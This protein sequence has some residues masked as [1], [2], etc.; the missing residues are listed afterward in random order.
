M[1]QVLYYWRYPEHGTGTVSYTTI[2]HGFAI[3]ENLEDYAFDYDK[4]TTTYSDDSSEEARQA[5]AELM[6]ACGVATE[7]DYCAYGSGTNIS[8]QMLISYFGIDKSCSQLYRAFFTTDKWEEIIRKELDEGRPVL[9]SGSSLEGGHQFVCDGYDE[10]GLYHIN[11]GWGGS[12]DGYYDLATLNPYDLAGTGFTADQDIIL[13][14]KPAEQGGEAADTASLGY[15]ALVNM[16]TGETA[17]GDSISYNIIMLRVTGNN[18]KGYIGTVLYDA[19]G[20][21]VDAVNEEEFELPIFYFYDYYP[22]NY[23]LPLDLA[24]GTYTLRPIYGTTQ[25]EWQPMDAVKGSHMAETI[26]VTV[27]NGVATVSEGDVKQPG[28]AIDGEVKPRESSIYAGSTVEVEI[29]IKNN[30]DY[31]NGYINV[32]S[33]KNDEPDFTDNMIIDAGETYVLL[34]ALPTDSVDT[35]NEFIVYF[36]DCNAR[37]DT[38]GTFTITSQIKAEGEPKISIEGITLDKSTYSTKDK[39][40]AYVTMSNEGGFYDGHPVAFVTTNERTWMYYGDGIQINKGEQ[41]IGTVQIDTNFL[42]ENC[43]V[44]ELSGLIIPGYYD[45]T[46]EEYLSSW[47]VVGFAVTEDGEPLELDLKLEGGAT[48]EGGKAYAG[49][50]ATVNFTLVNNG[51]DFYG[52]IGIPNYA[53]GTYMDVQET[54]IYAGESKDMQ[55]NITLQDEPGEQLYEVYYMDSFQN[56][57]L[58]GTFTITAERATGISAAEVGTE[59]KDAPVY[60]VSGQRVGTAAGLKSL[61]KG[62]YVTG[63]KKIVVK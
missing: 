29:P 47:Y 62:I 59:G 45:P 53:T 52:S 39:L 54:L 6:Y 60:T 5:V 37:R 40:V 11:W 16:T 58:A 18:F 32:K 63:G 49:Q 8:P 34:A 7:M 44:K 20:N 30:G 9:Y 2:T 56:V 48:I 4:M 12:L 1:A 61:P 35:E 42:L 27:E 14:I 38:I 13:G 19:E 10:T 25:D 28:L 33:K 50:E 3:E 51:D 43:G 46:T 55:M 26:V 22:I 23:A 31:F 17:L 21:M 15:E 24:D 57:N 41:K 36:E